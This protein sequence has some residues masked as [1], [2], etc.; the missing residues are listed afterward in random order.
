[1]KYYTKGL[2]LLSLLAISTLLSGCFIMRGVF[3]G[4]PD[5]KDISRFDSNPIASGKECYQFEKDKSGVGDR[6]KV[7]DRTSG[8]PYFVSLDEL[9]ES[10]PVRSMLVIRNDSL[11]YD[12]YR[13]DISEETLN[14]R[15][16]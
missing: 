3:L 11:L 10:R 9:N 7:N 16:Q 8:S 4:Y 6:L 14:P 5:S 2:L 15:I 13:K 1:M 12:F